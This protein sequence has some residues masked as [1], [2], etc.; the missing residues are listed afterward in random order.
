M[1][2]LN[3][4]QPKQLNS[5]VME[6]IDDSL[7]EF[8]ES[9]HQRFDDLKNKTINEV[10]SE[11]M[12]RMW[13]EISTAELF[14]NHKNNLL[15]AKRK[16]IGRWYRQFM[17]DLLKPFTDPK[18]PAYKEVNQILSAK[19]KERLYG[20]AGI[21]PEGIVEF[22]KKRMETWNNDRSKKLTDFPFL[23]FIRISSIHSSLL[24]EININICNALIEI[25]DG[26]VNGIYTQMFNFIVENP[27]IS[28]SNRATIDFTYDEENDIYVEEYALSDVDDTLLKTYISPADT[29]DITTNCRRSMD[30]TD[31]FII[32]ESLRCLSIDFISSKMSIVPLV[33]I[34]RYIQGGGNPSRDAYKIAEQRCFALINY[35]YEVFKHG[36][37][38]KAYNV[39]SSIDSTEKGDDDEILMRKA[40]IFKFSDEAYTNI[41]QNKLSRVL[42][43][44]MNKLQSSFCKIIYYALQNE[45]ISLGYELNYFN[46]TGNVYIPREFEPIE[47]DYTWFQM[48]SRMI[49]KNLKKNIE[50]IVEGLIEFK[51]LKIAIKDFTYENYRF[52]IQYYPLTPE[53]IEDLSHFNQNIIEKHM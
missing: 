20:N 27:V 25:C 39:Y 24:L 33:N 23:N 9:N 45:R 50:L 32:S 14:T 7:I 41:I 3:K 17:T 11:A 48:H 40:I 51:N 4:Y 8:F 37:M 43:L 16:K 5:L 21:T 38:I 1:T 49:Y 44:N 10:V 47:H 34:A 46:M 36:V 42:S 2:E 15:K 29:E 28:V 18:N 31:A 53:E 13:P 35:S 6:Y 52:R 19:D 12:S 22:H 30:T 26:D